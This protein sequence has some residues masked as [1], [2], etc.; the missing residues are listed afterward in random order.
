MKT[1]RLNQNLD[2]GPRSFSN[3]YKHYIHKQI[4]YFTNHDVYNIRCHLTEEPY[5]VNM[6][7]YYTNNESGGIIGTVWVLEFPQDD[8]YTA[9]ELTWG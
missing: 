1:L 6:T 4:S 2:S 3:F 5:D 7:A 9:F 8:D